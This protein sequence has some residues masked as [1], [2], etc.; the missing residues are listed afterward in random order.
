MNQSAMLVAEETIFALPPL[1]H[2]RNHPNDGVSG[3]NPCLTQEHWGDL[4]L[5]LNDSDDMLIYNSL[6]D[7]LHSGWSPFDSVITTVHPQPRPLFHA[8]SLPA[9][10]APD[11]HALLLHNTFASYSSEVEVSDGSVNSERREG[12][13]TGDYSLH[14]S[15]FCKGRHYRGVRQRPWGKYA[16][17]IRDPAKN[18]SRVW[19]GTYE[20]AEEAALA[21]DR[22]AYRMRGAKALLNFPHRIGSGE[23]PPV[24]VTAKRKESETKGATVGSAKK[25]KGAPTAAAAAK[26]D[27]ERLDA[28]PFGVVLLGEELLVS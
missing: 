27:G 20:T 7:A 18:G 28:F 24:R 11:G 16:A 14:R 23:P 25:P 13:F 21:Y 9:S 12:D 5:Q 22:A 2:Q 8:A 10:F 17:E 3:L 15:A 26:A 1:Y 4:P 6:H 19:L